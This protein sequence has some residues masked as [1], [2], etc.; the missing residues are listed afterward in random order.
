MH[1]VLLEVSSFIHGLM[2]LGAIYSKLQ[3]RSQGYGSS[4]ESSDS[5]RQGKGLPVPCSCHWPAVC[6]SPT[7][8]KI[9]DTL[10]GAFPSSSNRKRG[11]AGARH[12][13]Q[14]RRVAQHTSRCKALELNRG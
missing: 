1:T 14:G 4:G 5:D 8:Q 3:R 6:S 13:K 2:E 9:G 7:S 12:S 10:R 11:G